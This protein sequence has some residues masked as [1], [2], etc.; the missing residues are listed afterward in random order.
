MGALCMGLEHGLFCLGCCWVLMG[1]LFYGGIMNL[2]WISGLAL[3]V[4]L[5]KVA[6]VGH[7]AARFSGVALIVWGATILLQYNFGP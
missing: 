5:E 7:W 3:F 6:P 4:M 2:L 1:L